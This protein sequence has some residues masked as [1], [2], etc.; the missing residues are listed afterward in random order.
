MILINKI[1]KKKKKKIKDNDKEITNSSD[2]VKKTK[3]YIKWT[4]GKIIEIANKIPD[5]AYFVNKIISPLNST[6]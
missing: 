6:L 1:F 3:K 5:V 2:L 4:H